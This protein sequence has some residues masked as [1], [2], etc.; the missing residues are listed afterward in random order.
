MATDSSL[1]CAA[2]AEKTSLTFSS[3]A[4]EYSPRSGFYSGFYPT[5]PITG[6][7]VAR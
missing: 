6:E 2:A 5:P 4:L 3:P 7:L 1:V